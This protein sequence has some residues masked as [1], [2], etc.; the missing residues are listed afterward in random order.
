MTP[1]I[2]ITSTQELSK[3]LRKMKYNEHLIVEDFGEII[4]I[5]SHYT[6]RDLPEHFDPENTEFCV[7]RKYLLWEVSKVLNID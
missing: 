2:A 6:V 3:A 5:D 1:R 7:G 4:K